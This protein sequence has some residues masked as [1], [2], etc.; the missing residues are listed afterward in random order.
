MYPSNDRHVFVVAVFED[1]IRASDVV[2]RPAD[3]RVIEAS[4]T[5]A[6]LETDRIMGYPEDRWYYWSRKEADADG[7]A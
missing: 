5:S 6:V 4:C 1:K 3:R 2:G 7:S